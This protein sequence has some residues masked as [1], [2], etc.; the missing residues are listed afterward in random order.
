MVIISIMAVVLLES[1]VYAQG[2]NGGLSESERR[3]MAEKLL[4]RLGNTYNNGNQSTQQQPATSPQS[5]SQPP[6]S[7]TSPQ[8]NGTQ[9]PVAPNQA[10]RFSELEQAPPVQFEPV[11]QDGPVDFVAPRVTGADAGVEALLEDLARRRSEA[12]RKRRRDSQAQMAAGD[13]VNR[14]EETVRRSSEF[15]VA[16][17][18]EG[19][20]LLFRPI[21]ADVTYDA[22]I[23]AIN[24][25]G[26]IYLSF[27]D[28][29]TIFELAIEVDGLEAQGWFLREDWNFLMDLEDGLV[30]SRERRLNVDPIDWRLEGDVLF[31]RAEAAEQ[32]FSMDF[33]FNTGLQILYVDPEHPL[34]LI[35]RIARAEQTQASRS[36]E[37]VAVLPRLEPRYEWFDPNVLNINFRSSFLRNRD[38]DTRSLNRRTSYI[39]EGQALKHSAYTLVN[40]TDEQDI[41]NVTAR[42]SKMSEEPDLLGPLKARNYA[43]GD[44]QENDAEIL[45]GGD[46]NFGF[47]VDNNPLQF[48]DFNTTDIRGDGIP[49]WDVELYRNNSFLGIQRVQD[50]GQY[51]FEDI[52]L[53]LGDNF[54]EILFYGPQGEIRKE[55]LSLPVSQAFFASQDEIYEFSLT[56]DETST[57]QDTPSDDVDEGTIN[58]M[59]EY[60]FFLGQSLA[61]V[62]AR[63]ASI[64][65]VNTLFGGFGL[66]R[67]LDGT[68]YD[69]D[70]ALN[71]E[72][73]AALGFT[74]RRRLGEWN[75]S[76]ALDLLTEGYQTGDNEAQNTI[77]WALNR[78]NLPYFGQGSGLQFSA[79]YANSY[80][81]ADN[82]TTFGALTHRAGI[83]SLSHNLQYQNLAGSDFGDDNEMFYN[84]NL[85]TFYQ[86][87]LIRLGLNTDIVPDTEVRRYFAQLDYRYNDALSSDFV[88][89]HLPQE[90]FT[91][92][93][94]GL[95]YL[96]PWFR[97]TPF[98]EYDSDENLQVGIS[99]NTNLIADPSQALPTVQGRR[100]TGLGFVSALVYYD[101]NGNLQYDDDEEPL[102]GVMVESVNIKRR[103]KT[104]EN[105]YALIKNLNPVRATDIRIDPQTL[106]DPFMISANPGASV[107]P[108]AGEVVE[109]SFPIHNAGEVDGSVAIESPTGR[110]SSAQSIRMR[111]VPLIKGFG[112]PMR[113][114]TILDGFYLFSL[115]PPGRYA[116]YP[117]E[118]DARA[119]EAARPIPR[120]IDVGFDGTFS[121]ANDF[122]MLERDVDVPIKVS[123]LEDELPIPARAFGDQPRNKPYYFIRIEK[124]TG[125]PLLKVIDNIR[126]ERREEE[127][128]KGLFSFEV[129]DPEARRRIIR[130]RPPNNN[131]ERAHFLCRE[132]IIEG[133]RCFFEIIHPNLLDVPIDPSVEDF[134]YQEPSP[135]ER[136]VGREIAKYKEMTRDPELYELEEELGYPI[137]RRPGLIERV[138]EGAQG[139]RDQFRDPDAEYLKQQREQADPDDPFYGYEQPGVRAQIGQEIDEYQER[140]GKALRAIG[141]YF[142]RRSE[143][144]DID[145]GNNPDGLE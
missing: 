62:S 44:V 54:F 85:R 41:T 128:L 35:Q 13:D 63:Y 10:E 126:A 119:L 108:R 81:G 29:V 74:A 70:L 69:V 104:A 61:Q 36:K 65:G 132:M 117:D 123:Y 95:N 145:L 59:G 136:F 30:I 116:L 57:Y 99:L 94:I 45:G 46:Q 103:E 134:A 48:R 121:L 122:T 33:E 144:Y 11:M 120:I 76:L 18:P 23:F 24:R 27:D 38:R 91:E 53:F 137:E 106:P 73:E 100:S 31:V 113:A 17:I 6:L 47:R 89:E 12:E 37:N 4:N 3:S 66:S 15:A 83:F 78:S 40:T 50:D 19:G 135:F 77:E 112:K 125:S 109:L 14:L 68:L 131:P 88:V 42:L 96:H 142:K 129:V 127:I 105:G 28:I 55:T 80:T 9:E 64:E 16:V 97:L 22:D 43:F 75:S 58:A 34:P 82:F 60:R 93:R 2:N 67:T 114:R 32:W 138:R 8:E 84:F 101:R 139:L 118:E 98:V 1:P 124:K 143:K 115:V 25:G 20:S 7:I 26:N 71:S 141:D 92:A 110:I 107:F 72:A 51:V 130:Y 111:L 86:R 49:G 87:W 5:A 90:N 133:A 39:M 52:Q 140:A 79:R 56:L 21:S 102:P